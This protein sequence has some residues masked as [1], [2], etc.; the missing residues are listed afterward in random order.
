MPT[1][2]DYLDDL[3]EQKKALA[4]AISECGIEAS[5]DETLNTLVPKV[6]NI[7]SSG[8]DRAFWN[9]YQDN[10]NRIDYNHAFAGVG[11]NDNTFKPCYDIKPK[12]A[13]MMFRESEITSLP[14]GINFDFSTCSDLS[15]T[16]SLC[17]ISKLGTISVINCSSLANTF[18]S[19]SLLKKI[20]LLVVDEK[21]KFSNAFYGCTSLEDIRVSGIIANNGFDISASLLLTVESLNSIINA[22]ADKSADKSTTWKVTLGATNLAK[23]TDEQKAVATNKGWILE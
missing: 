20:D 18:R 13:Y 23:L 10:G 6:L 14:E 9:I 4:T 12:N 17:Q 5:E 1:T 3:V 22:L 16:F 11:W 19:A 8:D 21:N 2:A 7:K 15:Y